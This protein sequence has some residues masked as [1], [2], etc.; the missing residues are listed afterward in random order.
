MAVSDSR[1]AGAD[2]DEIERVSNALWNSDLIDGDY[3]HLSRLSCTHL[4]RFV[5]EELRS[6]R[7]CLR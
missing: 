1:Q 3:V 2:N 5:A 4:V 7:A 6:K